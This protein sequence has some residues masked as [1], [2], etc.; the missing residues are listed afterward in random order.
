MQD[1]ADTSLK[2]FQ[3]G[4]YAWSPDRPDICRLLAESRHTEMRSIVY[5][6]NACFLVLLSN[7][8]AEESFAIYKP[9]R[10]EYPLWDFAHGTLYKR[11][12]ATYRL[13]RLLGWSLVPPTVIGSGAYGR[14]SVQL[15][16]EEASEQ[17]VPADT[18]RRLVLLDW[19][20]NNADRK[21]DHLLV[22]HDGRLWGIDHGLTFH[23]QPK[24]RTV[25][26]HFAGEP[27]SDDEAGE[28]SEL[29]TNLASTKGH[30][31]MNLLSGDER[32]AILR[33]VKSLTAGGIFPNPQQ[34]AIPY[35]W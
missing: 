18:L 15:F 20:A 25:L 7:A 6:S 21:P 30:S 4:G 19:I 22:G 35:R 1:P 23:A 32:R 31:V 12:V 27:L 9:S 2:G 33:R 3:A 11:E 24:L 34:R 17:A 28:L 13:T 14:G 8:D 26:W 10:G 5:G 16:I 29:E